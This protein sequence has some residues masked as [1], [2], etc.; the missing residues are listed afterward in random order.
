MADPTVIECSTAC[1]V[2]LVHELSATP[3][4][5][6]MSVQDGLQ[7]SGLILAVWA[8]AAVVRWLVRVVSQRGDDASS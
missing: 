8:A 3:S 2:T 7:L 1:T 4:P 6:V 5:F